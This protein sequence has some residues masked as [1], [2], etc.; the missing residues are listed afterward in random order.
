MNLLSKLG[1]ELES[2]GHAESLLDILTKHGTETGWRLI[3]E[4]F[5]ERE[6]IFRWWDNRTVIVLK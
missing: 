1:R 2:N 3:E 6:I 4:A 5:R